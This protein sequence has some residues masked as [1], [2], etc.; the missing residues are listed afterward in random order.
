MPLTPSPSKDHPPR[1][2]PR[3]WFTFR[4]DTSSQLRLRRFQISS[5]CKKRAAG[6]CPPERRKSGGF[7][8]LQGFLFRPC[9][10]PGGRQPPPPAKK[11]GICT[12]NYLPRFPPDS[13]EKSRVFPGFIPKICGSFQKMKLSISRNCK[14]CA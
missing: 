14:L 13:N 2:M 8:G 9:F 7:T 3:C 6:A 12:K 5:E 4:R 10:P 11:S 1:T